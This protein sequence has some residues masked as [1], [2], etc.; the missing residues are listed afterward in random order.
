MA[1]G[2][3]GE[4]EDLRWLGAKG[5]QIKDDIQLHQQLAGH[6]SWNG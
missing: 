5:P 1:Q 2:N 3:S 4:H 6:D